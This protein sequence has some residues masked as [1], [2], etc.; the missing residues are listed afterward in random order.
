MPLVEG[1]MIGDRGSVLCYTGTC[2]VSVRRGLVK[3]SALTRTT[4]VTVLDA[5]KTRL[6][7]AYIVIET[8]YFS[9]ALT[10]KCV[11]QPLNDAI[12]GK[13]LACEEFRSPFYMANASLLGKVIQRG[14]TARKNPSRQRF[15]L[16]HGQ[17]R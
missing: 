12:L 3:N 11:E 4:L 10:A 1:E 6:R 16:V 15:R 14:I 13:C 7:E 17:A 9:G 8:S 5:V 2:T